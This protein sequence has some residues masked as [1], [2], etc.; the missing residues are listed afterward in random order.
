[1]RTAILSWV[2]VLV[3]AV[4]GLYA[5]AHAHDDLDHHATAQVDLDD[6]TSAQSPDQRPV[7]D[8]DRTISPMHDH[9]PPAG[10]NVSDLGLDGASIPARTLLSPA[11]VATLTSRIADPPTQPPTA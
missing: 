10:I 11:R 4:S 7:S 9:Q 5:P 8:D 2:L 6:Q 1:M 3:L